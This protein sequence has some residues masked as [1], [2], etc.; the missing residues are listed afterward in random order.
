MKSTNTAR[1][2]TS[3]WGGNRG[4]APSA[5]QQLPSPSHTPL[6]GKSVAPG[7][8]APSKPALRRSWRRM[9]LRMLQTMSAGI[10]LDEMATG[11]HRWKASPDN[12]ADGVSSIRWR[13]PP[14]CRALASG[15]ESPCPCS[16]TG[17]LP[18]WTQSIV[19]GSCARRKKGESNVSSAPARSAGGMVISLSRASM[20]SGPNTVA[21]PN[22]FCRIS[23][24]SGRACRNN[25]SL[26]TSLSKQ[27]ALVI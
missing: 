11:G 18:L 7:A 14:P 22:M 25:A 12:A 6:P 8:L 16:K 21:A 9:T 1:L 26:S 17:C 15:K 19:M 2:F 13:S 20:P 5:Q 3:N 23:S 10:R 27:I 4:K 24:R